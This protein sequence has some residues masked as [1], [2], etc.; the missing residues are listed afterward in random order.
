MR[1]RPFYLSA[2]ARTQRERDDELPV[3]EIIATSGNSLAVSVGGGGMA[4]TQTLIANAYA[5]FNERDIDGVFAL[6]SERVSWPKASE[7]GRAVGKD[8]IRAYWTR[9]WK[10]FDPHVEPLELI[11]RG[12]GKTDVRVHQ[13]V[14]NLAGDVTSDS[15]V[16]HTYTISNGLIDHMELKEDGASSGSTSSAAFSKH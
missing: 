9:Q 6:M 5:A 14:K 15:E 1:R 3:G 10:Q 13:V 11:G 7:G 16:W 2:S 4:D 12:D 8:E